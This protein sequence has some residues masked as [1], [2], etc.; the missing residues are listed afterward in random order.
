LGLAILTKQEKELHLITI[1]NNSKPE[2]RSPLKFFLLVYG[3]SIP[4]WIIGKRID[5]KGLPF[6]ITDMLAAFMPLVAASILVYKEEGLIGINKLF[7]RILDFS[8]I[9]KKI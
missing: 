4:L 2:N 9:T 5:V 3:L 1:M 7:K 8:R 6:P